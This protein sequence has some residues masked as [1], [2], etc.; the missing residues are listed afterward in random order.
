VESNADPRLIEQH[1]S[2]D[3]VSGG[4]PSARRLLLLAHLDIWGTGEVSTARRL[5]AW[6][7]LGVTLMIAVMLA[8]GY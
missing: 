6:V 1:S 3:V 2:S 8:L 7:A 5:A 4:V